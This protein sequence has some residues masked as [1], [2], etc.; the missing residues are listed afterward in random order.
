MRGVLGSVAGGGSVGKTGGC[1]RQVGVV[2]NLPLLGIVIDPRQFRQRQGR[3]EAKKYRRRRQCVLGGLRHA[4]MNRV[5]HNAADLCTSPQR[6][7]AG[8]TALPER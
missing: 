2:Q 1:R 7:R 8:E 3:L 6:E 5:G 4:G